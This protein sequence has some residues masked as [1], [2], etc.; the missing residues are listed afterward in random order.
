MNI[1]LLHKEKLNIKD[2]D[3]NYGLETSILMVYWT[4]EEKTE[5]W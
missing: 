3:L 5:N 2:Q 1:G 4:N